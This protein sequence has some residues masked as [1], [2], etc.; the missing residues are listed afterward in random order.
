MNNLKQH[1]R[2]LGEIFGDAIAEGLAQRLELGLNRQPVAA[3]IT[4][5]PP[6]GEVW[7]GQGGIYA[8]IIRNPENGQRWQLIVHPELQGKTTWGEEG[9]ETK[10]VSKADGASNTQELCAAG[11]HPAAKLAT[12]ASADGYTDY[13]LP[14]QTE[15]QL[16]HAN[17]HDK[18]GDD[19]CWSSTQYSAF[20]AWYQAFENGDHRIGLKVTKLAVR[21]VRR[22]LIL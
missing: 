11:K 13:Y 6:V 22:I 1:A 8:G 10:A 9:K 17:L 7:P 2:E 21:A 19:V 14:A 20:G 4:T 18:L 5:P 3:P 15:L 12:E 16:L